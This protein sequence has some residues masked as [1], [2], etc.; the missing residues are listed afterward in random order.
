MQN[1]YA[2]NIQVV[3]NKLFSG[4]SWWSREVWVLRS[5]L[6]T[7]RDMRG[8]HARQLIVKRNQEDSSP[9]PVTG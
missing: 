3:S 8:N 4:S 7:L 2:C 5:H 6:D 1:T 9:L